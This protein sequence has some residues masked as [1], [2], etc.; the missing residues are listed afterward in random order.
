MSSESWVV[1]LL[2]ASVQVWKLSWGGGGAAQNN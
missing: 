2:E 1:M